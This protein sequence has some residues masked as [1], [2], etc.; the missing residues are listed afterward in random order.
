MNGF[1]SLKFG[2]SVGV[3]GSVRGREAFVKSETV[4]T[5]RLD[6]E[7]KTAERKREMRW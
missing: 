7:R 4:L 3:R 2:E 5:E 6:K 1:V